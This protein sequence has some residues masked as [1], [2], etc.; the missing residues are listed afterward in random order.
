MTLHVMKGA[1]RNLFIFHSTVVKSCDMGIYLLASAGSKTAAVDL[2]EIK[3]DACRKM[4]LLYFT[5][6]SPWFGSSLIGWAFLL[7]AWLNYLLFHLDATEYTNLVLT[8]KEDKDL[9]CKWPKPTTEI[10][11]DFDEGFETD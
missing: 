7:D 2:C 11:I 8:H 9:N 10:P 5:E 4:I 6:Q 1:V 3:Q